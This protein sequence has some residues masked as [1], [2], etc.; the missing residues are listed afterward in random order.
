VYHSWKIYRKKESILP[1][2]CT[3]L[4]HLHLYG[5]EYFVPFAEM[6]ESLTPLLMQEHNSCS[7]R[8]VGLLCRYF[9]S[10]LSLEKRTE[11]LNPAASTMD[12]ESSDLID[13][14]EGDHRG[15]EAQ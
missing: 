12:H 5:T 8:L 11:I 13:V 7:G 1:V 2:I 6:H 3:L 10:H 14:V 9:S 4:Y 15:E